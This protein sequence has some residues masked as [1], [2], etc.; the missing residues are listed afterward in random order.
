MKAPP[1]RIETVMHPVSESLA[2]T[3]AEALLGQVPT[4]VEAEEVAAELDAIVNLLVEMEGFEELLTAAL[5]SRS[6]RSAVVQRIFQG[7]VSEPVEALLNVMASTGRLG[8]LR[9]LCRV[10]RSMLYRRQ[11]KR[12][13]TVTTAVPPSDE[14]RERIGLVLAEA[15]R[16]EPVLSVRVDPGVLGGMIVQVGDDVYDASVR[17]ELANLEDRLRREIRLEAPGGASPRPTPGREPGPE[18]A[19]AEG[20]CE[21]DACDVR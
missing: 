1:D 7:R 5:L 8:L 16:A 4:D 14:Q 13:V 15:L 20:D 18:R 9:A 19:E 2:R 12:E 11:G 3:Y 10:F 6:E 17:A 21:H